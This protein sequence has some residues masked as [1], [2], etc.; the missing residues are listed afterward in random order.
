MTRDNIQVN[1]S[2]SP[3]N[4]QQLQEYMINQN[5]SETAAI[6]DIIGSY[7]AEKTDDKFMTRIERL[8]QEIRGLKRHILAMRFRRIS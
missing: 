4:Y 8:E 3:E 5:L 2:L 6:N 7:L 1:I